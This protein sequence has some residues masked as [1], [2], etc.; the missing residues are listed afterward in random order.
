[1]AVKI[2]LEQVLAKHPEM[3][4][5]FDAR[6][7]YNEGGEV[8]ARCPKCNHVLVVTDLPEAGSRWVTCDSGCTSYH[9]KYKPSG[10]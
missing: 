4:Q 9:E 10:P 2:V 7:A 3:E 8:K 6:R 1:M 5:V